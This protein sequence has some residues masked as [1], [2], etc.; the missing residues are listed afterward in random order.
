VSII[1]LLPNISKVAANTDLPADKRVV[2]LQPEM[3]T[4][5]REIDTA[6]SNAL[7]RR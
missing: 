3:S 6:N 1:G 7:R 4:I 2:H 5:N